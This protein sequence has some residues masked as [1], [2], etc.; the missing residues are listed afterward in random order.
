M[1]PLKPKEARLFPEFLFQYLLSGQFSDDAISFQDRT[2]IPKI[3][4]QQIGLIHLPIPPITI[5]KKIATILSTI[6]Q[7][8][9]AEQSRRQALDALF[10][11]LLHDLMTAKI[12]VNKIPV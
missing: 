8:F 2:G 7:K 9:A 11:T 3:N 5:Q 1:Y 6:D 4:R 10:T 12:R